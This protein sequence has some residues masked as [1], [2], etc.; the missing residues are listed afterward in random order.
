[1]LKIGKAVLDL[2]DS[3]IESIEVVELSNIRQH[4]ISYA[5]IS[6]DD[7]MCVTSR[8]YLVLLLSKL[9][10][11]GKHSNAVSIIQKGLDRGDKY[12]YLSSK[13]RNNIAALES[14]VQ[15][16]DKDNIEFCEK[17]L[18]KYSRASLIDSTQ[19]S[20]NGFWVHNG[21]VWY[22][23]YALT[24][25]NNMVGNLDVYCRTLYVSAKSLLIDLNSKHKISCDVVVFEHNEAFIDA[26]YNKGGFG[27][28]IDQI[29]LL[30]PMSQ[31]VFQRV[32]KLLYN[33]IADCFSKLVITG[34]YWKFSFKEFKLNMENIGQ[35][36]M[37]SV[38]KSLNSR[39]QT[40]SIET[41]LKKE[42]KPTEHELKVGSR[43]KRVELYLAKVATLMM[44]C[45][46][47]E[48]QDSVT[49]D[50]LR[51]SIDFLNPDSGTLREKI[52]NSKFKDYVWKAA[53]ESG[54]EEPIINIGASI[55]GMW[56][57]FKKLML[58]NLPEVK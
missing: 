49:M 7:S 58:D 32:V 41:L 20:Y 36:D 21:T 14:N 25:A 16:K 15:S 42:F 40:H 38:I 11:S 52:E 54:E 12:F 8:T 53:H 37:G 3:E 43:R 39:T 17:E 4:W 2:D 6:T 35:Y 47:T 10:K 26:F 22:D 9:I 57:A 46:N 5:V 28:D 24:E 56:N 34:E 30:E 33:Y 44:L 1:M 23:T 45:K 27:Y 29:E 51:E 19:S 48:W 18:R 55:E 50:A 31:A 13:R